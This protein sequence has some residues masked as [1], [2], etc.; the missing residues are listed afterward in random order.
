[1]A[2]KVV[3]AGGGTVGHVTPGIAVAQVL[4]QRGSEILFV[5]T[6]AGPEA[7][8]ADAQ[9]F[10]FEP[11]QVAA[12]TGGL[13]PRNVIAGFKL[14]AACWRSLSILARF[15]PDVVVGTGGYVSLPVV[16]SAWVHRIPTV[17]H[18]QN[19]V[20]GLANRIGARF[21]RKIGVSFPDTE[22]SF[23]GRKATF[24]GN[25]VRSEIVR[26]SR[27]A[28]RPVAIEHFELD[29]DRATLLVVG[30]SQGAVSIN[31][32]AFGC[33]SKWRDRGDFQVLHLVGPANLELAE[34][35]LET[36]RMDSDRLIWRLAGYTDRIELAYAV[37]DLAVCRSGASTVAELQAS[38]IPAILIPYPHSLDDDQKRNAEVMQAAGAAKMIL[39][40]E[41]DSERFAGEVERLMA[42][43]ATSQMMSSAMK[44][45][46]VPDAAER[47]AQ[48]VEAAAGESRPSSSGGSQLLAGAGRS[49]RGLLLPPNPPAGP[50]ERARAIPGFDQGWRRFHLV[51]AGG[52]GMSS[53][54]TILLQAGFEVTGSDRS[55][56]STLQALREA[57]AAVV[58]GHDPRNVGPADVLFVS[59]AIPPGN[60]E[61]SEAR[62]RGIS[63]LSR[64]EA[65]ARIFEGRRTIAISGTHGKTTTSA[66]VATVL[67][68]CGLD[69][70]YVVGGK[71]SGHLGGRL[72]G[73]EWSVLEADEAFGS[74]L[75]LRPEIGLITNIDEDHLDF[76]GGLG[77]LEDAFRT[78]ISSTTATVVACADDDRTARLTSGHSPMLYGFSSSAHVSCADAEWDA[79]SAGF[80]V[81]VEGIREGRVKIAA[82]GRHNVQNALGAIGCGISV[83]L[84]IQQIVS[85]LARY[86]GVGR[87]FENK[88]TLNGAVMVDDYSHNPA[89]IEAALALARRG[90]WQRVIAVFQPHLYSRTKALWR[91]LGQALTAADVVVVTDVDGAREDPL[92]GISGKMVADAVC[93]SSPGKRVVYLP[94]LTQAADFVTQEAKEGDVFVT[95]G[96]GYVTKLHDMVAVAS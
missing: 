35:E 89:E 96:C 24:V 12:R 41:L 36:L 94:E 90:G 63:V 34:A 78:F 91:E 10:R 3:I 66:M 43:T 22:T 9:G 65:L 53:I 42:D 62:R 95:L 70:T 58:A 39:D 93:E 14:L 13:S 87:R 28:I 45:G 15:D 8:L 25:P 6:A 29:P 46:A 37:A 71:Y 56:S 77:G 11:I 47:L 2:M 86:R 32:A 59:S 84:S 16:L 57:G 5:G 33:Y 49:F 75:L 20:P 7:R 88:G 61:L 81:V 26:M 18:E 30:G 79:W 73:G 44:R 50:V 38:G 72:G 21:A 85:A 69:P 23:G 55:E 74:F 64:G 60:V 31:R 92:P 68:E 27:H 51:G 83:G 82:G 67:E 80:D 1:M 4:K 76:Y 17:L 19:A 40:P 48:L 52:A 54:A